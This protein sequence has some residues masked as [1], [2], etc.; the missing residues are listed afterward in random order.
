LGAIGGEGRAPVAPGIAL[1]AMLD[2]NI[3]VQCAA[4]T[5]A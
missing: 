1:E 3:A 4:E 5:K 2:D